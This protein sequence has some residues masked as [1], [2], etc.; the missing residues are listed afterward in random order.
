MARSS[1]LMAFAAVAGTLGSRISTSGDSL[2]EPATQVV[3]EK[4][5]LKLPLEAEDWDYIGAF[6][7][8]SGGQEWE[9]RLYVRDTNSMC[10][11]Q[12]AKEGW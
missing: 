2:A 7:L 10:E 12:I 11:K 3:H 9:T 6:F 5:E 8:R 4:P 1:L